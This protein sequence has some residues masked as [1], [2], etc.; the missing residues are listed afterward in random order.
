LTLPRGLNGAAILSRREAV[1]G[2]GLVEICDVEPV[3]DVIK[4][5]P[6]RAS[7]YAA[8]EKQL[9]CDIRAIKFK[10]CFEVAGESSY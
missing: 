7:R 5:T 3:A 9:G 8:A 1:V 6:L 2:G 4:D 10:C